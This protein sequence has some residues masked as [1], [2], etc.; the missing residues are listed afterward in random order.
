MPRKKTENTESA[1]TRTPTR[2]PTRVPKSESSAKAS[3]KPEPNTT[4]TLIRKS[5]AARMASPITTS[6]QPE[7]PLIF[8]YTLRDFEKYRTVHPNY[9][10]E[11][12]GEFVTP[13]D[14]KQYLHD[15]ELHG[16]FAFVER[17]KGKIGRSWPVEIEP[18][19]EQSFAEDLTDDDLGILDEDDIDG[20]G[21]G[22]QPLST[23]EI[24]LRIELAKA[25]AKLESRGN[26]GPQSSMLEMVEGLRMIDEM[27]GK[28]EPKQANSDADFF[29]RLEATQ[30]F[31][32]SLSPK[33]APPTQPQPAPS[34]L[35]FEQQMAK[36]FEHQSFIDALIK[37]AIGGKNEGE[38][39]TTELMFEHGPELLQAAG[40]HFISP[41][42]EVIREGRQRRGS[43]GRAERGAAHGTHGA[44][45]PPE[46]RSVNAN[47]GQMKPDSAGAVGA[48]TPQEQALTQA[49]I[50]E[51]IIIIL[52]TQCKQRLPP[53]V[54]YA[55]LVEVAE[56]LPPAQSI[57]PYFDLFANTTPE[58]ARSAVKV[59]LSDVVKQ[60]VPDAEAVLDAPQTLGWIEGLQ[61]IIKRHGEE[62]E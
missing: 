44:S 18:Q 41:I 57:W 1:P 23:T 17:L 45:P 42:V 7:L 3:S 16:W 4:E 6:G 20:L 54:A 10:G 51:Q 40:Q 13:S 52:L 36:V 37:K 58:M 39:S 30:K 47:E 8:V 31:L 22:G 15:H 48:V 11:K 5:T 38:K 19:E 49:T 56:E 29:E 12:H 34:P 9:F 27:R 26:G 24:K 53:Q 25:K 43:E 14:A 55:R 32:A 2:R 60:I 62:E 21:E 28:S 59:Q 61:E 50:E 35:T 46:Q 33:V